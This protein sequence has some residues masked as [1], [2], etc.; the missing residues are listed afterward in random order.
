MK[1]PRV[2]VKKTWKKTFCGLPIIPLVTSR[3]AY[4]TVEEA[5]NSPAACVW[6]FKVCGTCRERAESQ[7]REDRSRSHGAPLLPLSTRGRSR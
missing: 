3:V 7:A 2:H 4:P 5:K 1:D 6:G